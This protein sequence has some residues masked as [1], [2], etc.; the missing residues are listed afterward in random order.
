[1]VVDA[2]LPSERDVD[3]PRGHRPICA[4]LARGPLLLQGSASTMLSQPLRATSAAILL[5]ALWASLV[6][7]PVRETGLSFL[8]PCVLQGCILYA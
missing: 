5:M 1:M 6:R 8:F 3:D 7:S 4:A 2:L